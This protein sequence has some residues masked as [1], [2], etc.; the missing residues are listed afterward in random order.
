MKHIYK[1]LILVLLSNASGFAQN[2]G[3]GGATN[4]QYPLDV[5]GRIRIRFRPNEGAGLW[6]NKPDNTPGTFIGQTSTGNFGIAN[7]STGTWSFAFDHIN[8]RLGI[9]TDA[10]ASPVTVKFFGNGIEKLI[11]A[12]PSE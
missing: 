7:N 4:P 3:I 1:L 8:T 10:P 2:M 12:A 11:R 6:F 5:N 9:G